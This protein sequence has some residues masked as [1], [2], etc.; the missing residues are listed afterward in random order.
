MIHRW[1]LARHSGLLLNTYVFTKSTHMPWKMFLEIAHDT[2][3]SMPAKSPTC[4]CL[5][6]RHHLLPLFLLL[7]QLASLLLHQQQLPLLLDWQPPLAQQLQQAQRQ[8]QAQQRGQAPLPCRG[9]LTL[10]GY[11]WAQ[12]PLPL[13]P[14]L[15][16]GQLLQCP[17][18][19][20]QALS[21]HRRRWSLQEW[22]PTTHVGS[23]AVRRC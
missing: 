19:C 6:A 4:H 7:H 21:R 1:A 11:L 12:L 15:Q 3:S 13:H 17:C 9:W 5:P 23:E 18:C 22:Q 2:A 20:L 14:L 10:L 16:L 8:Q